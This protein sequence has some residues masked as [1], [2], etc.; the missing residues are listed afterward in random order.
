MSVVDDAVQDGIG[1]CR[2][3][4]QLM[5]FVDR[6]LAGD[7]GR[8]PAIAFFEDFEKVVASRSVE[9][10]KAPIVKDQQ[11]DAAERPQDTSVAT[12][13]AGSPRAL[14][15]Q[16]PCCGGRM[17]IIEVFARGCEPNWRPPPGRNDTS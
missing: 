1:I 2:I 8:S 13:T 12:I 14:S 6:D 16:C 15:P 4:D 3:P 9:R 17:I 7:N 5:P 11:L 10:L